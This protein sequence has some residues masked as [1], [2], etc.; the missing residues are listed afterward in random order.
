MPNCPAFLA[1]RPIQPMLKPDALT[2]ILQ[3]IHLES[4]ILGIGHLTAPWGIR[5]PDDDAEEAV[6]YVVMRGCCWILLNDRSPPILVTHGDLVILLQS[7]EHVICDDPSS[8]IAD[9][10]E[11]IAMQP[12]HGYSRIAFGGG[13]LPTEMVSGV[14]K[15]R[16]DRAHNPLLAALPAIVHI[17]NK[18]GQLV[19]WLET[20]LQFIASEIAINQ[21]GCQTVLARLADVL[22]IQAVR[23]Y[24]ADLA[25][26]PGNWLGALKDIEIGAALSLMHRSPDKAW[27]VALLA[28]QIPMSRSAFSARFTQLVGQPP[29]QYLATWRMVKAADLLRETQLEMRE[30]AAQ[31]GYESEVGFSKAFKRWA[32]IAPGAYR[33]RS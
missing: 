26:E 11:V 19:P 20:T 9:L 30:I 33:R 15:F 21:L 32:G 31:V 23:A 7:H 2:D 17:Q 1:D 24:I 12:H 8:P 3:T 4:T 18:A 14:F 10:Q 25:I 27:T 22:F 16:G 13:G 5:I 6:I 29:M 28:E